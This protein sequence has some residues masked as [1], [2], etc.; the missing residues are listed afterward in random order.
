MSTKTNAPVHN[1]TVYEI[2]IPPCVQLA[3]QNGNII[4]SGPAGKVERTFPT[5][6]IEIKV[7]ENKVLI[8][9]KN[10]TAAARMIAGAFN[11]HIKNIITGVQK[12][13]TYKLKITF[14]HFPITASISGSEFSVS[15]F[16]G[17][18]K[19]RK[20]SIPANVKVSIQGNI[21]TVESP[22]IELAGRTATSIEQTTQVRA[23]DRRVFPDGIYIIQKPK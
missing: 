15:N 23:R 4:A 21:I 6:S 20:T 16:L 5:K 22:D 14:T 7:E 9:T 11:S 3:I 8:K 13:Y 17:E 10:K 2:I 18:K 19:P 1:N 12:P